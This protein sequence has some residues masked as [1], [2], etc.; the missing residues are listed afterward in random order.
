MYEADSRDSLFSKHL[1]AGWLL[2]FLFIALGLVLES[3]QGFKFGWY[4]DV[5]NETRRMMLRL[6]HTH[7]TGL[8]LIQL[9]FAFTVRLTGGVQAGRLMSASRC[10][11]AA[12][13]LIPGGFFLGGI[14]VFGSDPGLGIWLVPVGAL[15]LL[16]A[17]AMTFRECVL[18]NKH[19]T[20]ASPERD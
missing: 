8:G 16:A 3:F 4:L 6:A 11:Q 15:C 7:G 5:G 1:R 13:A 20:T 9:A 14:Q 19:A 12:S 17:V 10:L 18:C 2:L